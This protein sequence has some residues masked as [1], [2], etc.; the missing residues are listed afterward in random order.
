MLDK[1]IVLPSEIE[2]NEIEHEMNSTER[3]DA[4][5]IRAEDN[6]FDFD[7]IL[8]TIFFFCASL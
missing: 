3:D 8:A 7:S 1:N 4:Y 6:L 2:L 5:D